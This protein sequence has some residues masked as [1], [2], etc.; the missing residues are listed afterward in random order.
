MPDESQEQKVTFQDFISMI[1]GSAMVGLGLIPN[2]MTNK[3]E[4]D[5]VSVQHT[6]SMLEMIQEKTKGN[7]TKEEETLMEQILH[8]LRMGY[9]ELM[10]QQGGKPPE[11]PKEEEKPSR[12]I[13][14]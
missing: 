7:L 6:I 11:T 14:P 8:E 10:K 1:S 13:V 2:P 9:V 12:I 5:L 4:I 3:Q